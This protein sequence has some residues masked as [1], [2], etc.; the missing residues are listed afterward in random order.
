MAVADRPSAREA[1]RLQT[2]ERLMCAAISEFKR[3]GIAAA[4]VR[5]IVDPSAILKEAVRLVMGIERSLGDVLFKD[6]PAL[7]F[8]QTRPVDESNQHPIIVLG[9]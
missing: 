3:A 7:H 1:K 6:F 2:R 8:S 9:R 4:D 5:A